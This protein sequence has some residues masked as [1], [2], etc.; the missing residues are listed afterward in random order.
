MHY[1]QPSLLRDKHAVR[2]ARMRWLALAGVVCA[3]AAHGVEP[4][5]EAGRCSALQAATAAA[6]SDQARE[7]V[8]VDANARAAPVTVPFDWRAATPESQG[9]SR[10]KLDALWNDLQSRHS[11]ALLVIRND[12]IVLE[13]YAE[14]WNASKPHGT[15]SMAKA[16][17]GG[18]VLAVAI[19]DGRMTLDDTAATYIPAW[20]NDPRKS[21]ITIRQLGSHTSGLDD[22]ESDNMR[23]E[24][25]TGW[26]GAFWKRADPPGDPFTIARDLTPL[27]FK[28][29]TT[30]LYSN[31]GIAVMG[32]AVAA[33]LKDSPQKDMRTLL[34]ERVMRPIGVADTEWSVGYGTTYVVDGLPLV[35]AWGG[36]L[37]HRG[38]RPGWRG[39]CFAGVIGRGRV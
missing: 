14:G 16:L 18:V 19:S 38:P 4:A 8:K 36:E 11:T 9:M 31:P 22:A 15:A 17:V 20:K 10:A 34:R 23:H 21:L 39:S 12:R 25:L 6:L 37:S 24:E 28:P 33:A 30:L 5:R 2:R 1:E 35:P 7:D 26:K 3:A 32:Y 27:R 13:R 29:G